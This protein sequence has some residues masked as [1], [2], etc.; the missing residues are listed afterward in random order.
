MATVANQQAIFYGSAKY[1]EVRQGVVERATLA[2][3]DVYDP[4]QWQ[5]VDQLAHA[6]VMAQFRQD[7]VSGVD[8]ASTLQLT[9]LAAETFL[10]TLRAVQAE[11]CL[12][13]REAIAVAE[14]EAAE[15]EAN[16]V[17]HG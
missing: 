8:D 6:M 17:A 4:I 3:T 7:G 9:I 13:L 15:A 11:R 12:E 16:G 5:A 2:A 10:V 1:R 14:S